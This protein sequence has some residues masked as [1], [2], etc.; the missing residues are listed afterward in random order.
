V[1]A[2]SGVSDALMSAAMMGS[3][4]LD[5]TLA[6]YQQHL[7]PVFVDV[8][9]GFNLC[10]RYVRAEGINLWDD[11]GNIY[12]DFF[13]GFGCL[14]LGHNHPKVTGALREALDHRQPVFHK[15]SPSAAEAALAR[16]LA[17]LLP[18]PLRVC[19]FVNSGSEAVEAAVKLAR[20]ATGRGPL[21]AAS[22]GYHGT[23]LG[24]LSLTG[25]R[26][27]RNLFTPMRPL[28]DHVP[29]GDASAVREAL[30]SRRYAAIVLEP[31]Q[32]QGGVIVPPPG[33]LPYVRSL[34]DQ[35]GTLL[36]L[37]ESQTGLGRTG[38]MFCFEHFGIVP[39]LLVLSKSL[40][41]GL[42]PLSACITSMPLWKRAY[43]SFSKFH[44][45][46]STF[47]GNSLACICGAAALEAL[48]AEQ[49]VQNARQ[50]GQYFIDRLTRLK[51]K[52]PVIAEVR[53][54]GLMIGIRF[55][56]GEDRVLNRVAR[57]VVNRISPKIVTSHIASRLLNEHRMI[58]P[59]SLS[60]EYLVRVYPPLNA[61]PEDLD[62]FVEALDSVCGSLGDYKDL[63]V[64]TTLRF[65]KHYASTRMLKI[66]EPG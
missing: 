5:S 12:W 44:L 57:R 55:A 40:G 60:D 62:R 7:N 59:P 24:A 42:M 28:V 21:I 14:N 33:Y 29:F 32:G 8:V 46:S 17:L 41:G 51:E 37:D 19:Y 65:G 26:K 2:Q 58:V 11:A 66:S 22:N 18:A 48:V 27:Y 1:N 36:V 39:D 13:S 56:M 34:C 61:T 15:L 50:A 9:R 63:L 30:K 3:L 52:H 31:I 16:D 10:R 43:G 35:S 54:M 49:L 20:A 23:T 53:G 45:H 47:G 38:A 4:D 64:R 6:L 25:I